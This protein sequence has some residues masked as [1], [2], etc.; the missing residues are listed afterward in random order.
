MPP[1]MKC[2]CTKCKKVVCQGPSLREYWLEDN[3]EM[4]MPSH[5]FDVM[6]VDEKRMALEETGMA[7]L[8]IEAEM[9]RRSGVAEMHYDFDTKKRVF[10][11]SDK[12]PV[13]DNCVHIMKMKFTECPFCKGKLDVTPVAFT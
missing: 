9:A 8:E 6:L 2:F 10:I 5:P 13:P 7:K 12:T 11:D 1:I 4:V 3:G